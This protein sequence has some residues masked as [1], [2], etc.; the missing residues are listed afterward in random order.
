MESIFDELLSVKKQ[1]TCPQFFLLFEQ[2]GTALW[3]FSL[4]TLT[5]LLYGQ[6]L[7]CITLY[8]KD[9]KSNFTE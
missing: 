1:D 5:F 3:H 4:F 2:M 6:K 9:P 7:H 8:H